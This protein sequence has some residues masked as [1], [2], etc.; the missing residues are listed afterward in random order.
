[1]AEEKIYYSLRETETE[2]GVPASTLRYWEK[3]FDQ[4]SP[5]KDGHGNRYYTREEQELIKRI[6]YIRDEL[7]ITRIEAIRKE[8]ASNTKRSDERQSALDILLRVR[9]E[10]VEIRKMIK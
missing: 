8:L 2:T 1:M 7:K 4:L 10:L 6:K 9:E 5:R 3:E